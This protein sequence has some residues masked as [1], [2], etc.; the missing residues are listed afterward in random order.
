ALPAC[1]VASRLRRKPLIF[2]TYEL[3]LETLALSDMTAGRRR[4]QTFSTPFIQHIIPRCAG[5]IT[6]SA[7]IAEEIRKRYNACNV[8]VVRNIPPHRTVVRTDRLRRLLGLGP[9]KRIALYQGYLQPD[10]GL[11][12]LICA[13][14]FLDKDVVIVMMGRDKLG[15]QACLQALI[16]Q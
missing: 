1:Y 14:A 6:V 12:N 2:E 15:T 10:R 9:E 13:A 8:C 5:V 7:P 3:P 11:D 16:E 4:L